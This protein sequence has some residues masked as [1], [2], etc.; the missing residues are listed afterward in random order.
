MGIPHNPVIRYNE[1][2]IELAALLRA[3][4][5]S[6][7]EFDG[8]ALTQ[9]GWPA[10]TPTLS[11]RLQPLSISVFSELNRRKR[12]LLEQGQ[13]FI[14]LSIGSPDLPPPAKV[15]KALS[16]AVQEPEH[17]GYGMHGQPTFHQAVAEFYASRYGVT[18]SPQTEV[19]Q[20]MGSQDGL[21]HLA[22][23]LL[24]PGDIV[25]VPDPGYP[26]YSASVVIAGGELYPMPLREEN[27]F[28]PNLD[29]IPQEIAHRAKMM[30]LNYPSNP[31]TALADTQFFAQVVQFAQR[32]D[33][34]VVHDFAY[35][36]LVFDGLRPL[37]FLSVP[38]AREVGI[39]FNS[40]SKTFN[41]A[42]C[43]IGYA[44]GKKELLDPLALLKSHLDYGLFLP[45]QRAAEVALTTDLSLLAD[46]VHVYERRRDTLVNA[47][48]QHGWT[49]NPPK[50]T[51]FIW[52]RL[53]NGHS[54]QKFALD[55][56]EEAGVVVT[57]GYAFG[58]QGENHVR[59]ALVQP[60]A[61]LAEAGQRMGDH[62]RRRG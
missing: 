30:I 59:I 27:R 11:T 36:E 32:Y 33:I 44:V 39:E 24:N 55:L 29:E 50:A 5:R 19:L 42:G 16:E 52:A 48:A 35:S 56:M 26:I 4:S 18:L 7:V 12:E 13:T 31:V 47:L 51:M 54:S 28:L 8:H 62:L 58:P 21:G 22:M 49:V 1:E 61:V 38:G 53:P 34:L 2:E 45:I 46:Q 20:L 41:M 23:A 9:K 43:R 3:F 25:L 14:D 40:L 37:S 10:M 15:R 57:P 6:Q 60:E 17:Y